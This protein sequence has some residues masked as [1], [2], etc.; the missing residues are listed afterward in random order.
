MSQIIL[1]HV[2]DYGSPQCRSF[3]D[4]GWI[5]PCLKCYR[6]THNEVQSRNCVVFLCRKC[7][8]I[9]SEQSKMRDL[10]FK[11]R[12]KF[13]F[14][15]KFEDLEL[16]DSEHAAKYMIR[17]LGKYGRFKVIKEERNPDV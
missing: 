14:G 10:L 15:F 9:A 2:G 5:F 3:P 11:S 17:C 12:S 1:K 8:K 7:V 4:E 6:I 16:S 13:K